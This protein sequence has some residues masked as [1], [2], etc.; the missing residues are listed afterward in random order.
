MPCS[1]GKT[2]IKLRYNSATS[3]LRHHSRPKI[4]VVKKRCRCCE[5]FKMANKSACIDFRS[6]D[7]WK[8][9]PNNDIFVLLKHEHSITYESAVPEL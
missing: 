1:S 5:V 6:I 9:K 3:Q 4:N 8:Y 7:L 2:I